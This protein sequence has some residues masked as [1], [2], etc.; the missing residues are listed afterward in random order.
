MTL[1][2]KSIL[3]ESPKDIQNWS[4]QEKLEIV[5]NFEDKENKEISMNYDN[6]KTT[7]KQIEIKKYL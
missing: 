7:W 3:G 2:P 6:I 5:Q 4:N 1:S